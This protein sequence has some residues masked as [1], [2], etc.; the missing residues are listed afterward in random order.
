MNAI[1]RLNCL[2]NI[3]FGIVLVACLAILIRQAKADVEREISANITMVSTLLEQ[4]VLSSE[5]SVDR[6]QKTLTRLPRLRHLQLILRNQSGTVQYNSRSNRLDEREAP[7][8]F[9]NLVWDAGQ[10]TLQKKLYVGQ[11]EVLLIGYPWDELDEVWESA[12]RLLLLLL[13]CALLSNLAVVWGGRLSLR[14]IKHFLHAL[15]QIQKGHLQARLQTYSLPET[16]RLAFHFNRM[17]FA[18]EQQQQ[19]NRSLTRKLMGL[20]EQERGLVARELH[21]DLGQHLSAINALAYTIRHSTGDACAV[22]EHA[23]KIIHNSRTMLSSFRNLIQRLRPVVLDRVDIYRASQHLC[24]EWS[25]RVGIDCHFT[26]ANNLPALTSE[27]SIHLYR[28]LQEALNNVTKHASTKRVSVSFDKLSTPEGNQLVTLISDTGIGYNKEKITDGVGLVFMRERA[29]AMGGE[30]HIETSPGK[31][32]TIS[33]SIAL[34]S[35]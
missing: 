1:T 18:L 20:Q 5:D 28:I 33:L 17:A 19:A 4:V 2:V 34:D 9:Q 25:Q 6:F 12:L 21:D 26:L 22:A 11:S 24:V 32:V 16:R 7:V 30:L 23:D 35:E 29:H 15:D 13:G 8:W 27:Q 31:G 3:A 10:T 14:P